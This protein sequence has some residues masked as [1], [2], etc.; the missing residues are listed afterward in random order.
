MN[1]FVPFSTLLAQDIKYFI[2][3]MKKK[4]LYSLRRV[5]LMWNEK[6]ISLTNFNA[7]TE[8]I[9]L[10][11]LVC[12]SLKLHHSMRRAILLVLRIS[13]WC[14]GGFLFNSHSEWAKL[15]S[16]IP[17]RLVDELDGGLCKLREV[18][19]HLFLSWKIYLIP[20]V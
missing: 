13:L 8:Q 5:G 10:D 4:V 20:M 16:K 11:N 1:H 14:F 18:F 17:M 12:F 19:C 7:I 9:V 2:A 15:S 6:E 3:R